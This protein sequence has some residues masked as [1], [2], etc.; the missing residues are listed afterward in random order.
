MVQVLAL[1]PITALPEMVQTLGVILMNE[2]ARPEVAVAE[3]VPVPPT[4]IVG[5]TPKVM[6]WL[7]VAACVM[8][9]FAVTC[10]AAAKLELPA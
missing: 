6:V 5:T 3:T 4:A 8:G 2:T 7:A 1:M 10:G 9:M